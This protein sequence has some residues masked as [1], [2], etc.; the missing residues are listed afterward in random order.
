MPARYPKNWAISAFLGLLLISCRTGSPAT[1]SPI[2]EWASCAPG[3]EIER[4]VISGATLGQGTTVA[5]AIP[6][7]RHPTGLAVLDEQGAIAACALISSLP[8]ETGIESPLEPVGDSL[9][10]GTA[11]LTWGEGR[12]EGRLEIKLTTRGNDPFSP[13]WAVLLGT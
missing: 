12:Y 2:A 1:L 13:Y 3:L 11:L 6:K 8:S 4:T 9:L 10:N 5:F 7:G